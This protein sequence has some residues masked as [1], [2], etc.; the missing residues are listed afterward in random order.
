M[1]NEEKDA[2]NVEG[3]SSESERIAEDAFLTG[4]VGM[5]T[6]P[7]LTTRALKGGADDGES[8]LFEDESWRSHAVE[9]GEPGEA[10][11]KPKGIGGRLRRWFGG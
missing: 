8:N 10:P 5:A 3:Q 6:T 4:A 2:A 7:R 1:G 9:E 11:A